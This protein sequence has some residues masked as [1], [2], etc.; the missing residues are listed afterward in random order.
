[1]LAIAY[2]IVVVIIE[3]PFYLR[4]FSSSKVE[5]IS[6]DINKLLSAFIIILFSFNCQTGLFTIISEL[7]NPTDDRVNRVKNWSVIIDTSF[8]A[9]ISLFGYLSTTDQTPEVIINRASV[10]GKNDYF[11]EVGQ[12]LLYICIIIHIPVN[13]HPLRRSFVNLFLN[14]TKYFTTKQS[15]NNQ[16]L[17]NHLSHAYTEYADS[18]RISQGGIDH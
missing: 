1:M 2:V 15:N 8:Y 7:K 12:I 11:M 3:F 6:G 4:R 5:W 10:F 9:T 14:K 17:D 16:E 13:Y 18:N